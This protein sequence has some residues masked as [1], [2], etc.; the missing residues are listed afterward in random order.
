MKLSVDVLVA[1]TGC[2]PARAAQVLLLIS[3]AMEEFEINTPRRIAG[4]LANVGVESDGLV[5]KVESLS[6]SAARMAQV[7]PSRYA[8]DPSSRDPQPNALARSLERRPEALANNVYANRMGNGPESSGDGWK[9]RGR[10]PIQMTGKAKYAQVGSRLKVDLVGNPDLAIDDA[11]TYRT[12]AAI[13]AMD[14]CNELLDADSFSKSVQVI[15]GALPNAA[16]AGPTR[17]A[18]YRATV[19]L[20]NA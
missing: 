13:W 16:N 9:Y 3:A 1:A 11:V 6:Y 15:N 5:A 17:L 12:A 8:V 14:G 19:P 20:L 4:F 7:W 18:R 2:K 10:G